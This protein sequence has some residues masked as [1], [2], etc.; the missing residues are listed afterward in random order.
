MVEDT[1]LEPGGRVLIRRPAAPNARISAAGSD[2]TQGELVVRRG[3]L[4]TAR[5]TGTLAACGLDA[6]R[7]HRRPR[8][9]VISTGNEIVPP[10]SA[11]APGEVHDANATLLVDAARELGVAAEALGVVRDDADALAALLLGAIE[12]FDVLLL[13]GGTSKGSGDISYRVVEE[14]ADVR[15]HGVGLKPGKPLCLA[16]RD[17][18]PIAILPGFP[19]SAIF[20]FH[21]FVAPVLRRLQGRG[22][23]RPASLRART[24]RRLPSEEGRAEFNLVSLVRGR[25]GLIAFPLGKGSGSVTTFARADGFIEI[26]AS[27]A[28]VD[29]GALVDVI[30]LGRDVE[31]A[32]LVIVGSHCTGLDRILDRVA[33]SGLTIKVLSVGSRGGLEAARLGACDLAPIHLYD[34]ERG[35]YNSSFVEPGLRLL[36]GY[37]RMQGLAFRKGE[38][39]HMGREGDGKDVEATLR[40]LAADDSLRLANRN[41]GSGTRAL[42]EDVLHG[43]AARPAGWA[44][45]YST[46]HAVAAAVAQRRADWG[47]CLG[48]AARQA[49][50]A[51]RP[52]R[53]EHYDFLVPDDRWDG[54]GVRAFRAA[55]ADPDVRRGLAAE[56]L[57][58]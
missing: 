38:D 5:E 7:C 35:T 28:Y 54:T 41:A 33:A 18:K 8:V 6:V 26:P 50:L 32:D 58:P 25:E 57:E 10:G 34:P 31:P 48:S 15:A 46:H 21:A 49:G 19:T 51:W 52:L 3:T 55:L 14:V 44:T 24:P 39:P 29:E 37:G 13:S 36:P 56:G 30:L 16:A 23:H 22:E 20:T 40:R 17:E 47:V 27:T 42:I 43:V 9:G 11:L 4:L 53:A 45:G 2:V 12:R 1:E